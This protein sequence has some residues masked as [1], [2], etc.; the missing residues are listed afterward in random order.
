MDMNKTQWNGSL[1]GQ[2]SSGKIPPPGGEP[3]QKKARGP[4]PIAGSAFEGRSF[5]A[6]PSSSN[7][8]EDFRCPDP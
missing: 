5:C 6:E 7:R 1:L 8:R 2:N 3:P 4:S